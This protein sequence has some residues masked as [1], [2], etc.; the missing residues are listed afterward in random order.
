MLA[1]NADIMDQIMFLQEV[2]IFASDSFFQATTVN[3]TETAKYVD[4]TSYADAMS[5]SDAKLWQ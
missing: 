3:F 5:W 1:R 4:P 2:H